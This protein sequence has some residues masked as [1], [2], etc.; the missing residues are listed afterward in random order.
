MK[1][2]EKKTVK[3]TEQQFLA[4]LILFFCSNSKG[5]QM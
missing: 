2:I 1:K 5:K 4:K 3:F